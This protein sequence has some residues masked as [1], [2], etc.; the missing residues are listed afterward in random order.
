MASRF[1]DLT[2][3]K[4]VP[5]RWYLRGPFRRR[6]ELDARDYTE[7]VKRPD[8]GPLA[9]P[10]LRPGKPLDWTEG[11][12]A[13][14]VVSEKVSNILRE[15]APDDVQLFPVTVKG[16]RERYYI[17]NAIHSC[18]CVDEKR[19]QDVR[20]W[21]KDDFRPDLA[22]RY[23]VIHKLIINPRRTGGHRLFRVKDWEVALIASQEIKDA[24]EEAGV[25]GA[26][27]IPV[28]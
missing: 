19:S 4:Y 26:E 2:D 12:Y 20:R 16:R 8:P 11:D 18:A 24:F 21:T 5:G 14:P 17:A 1:Y 10:L 6:T 22:G 28:T 13:M 15:L 23:K 27:F 9:I 7:G 25:L 3:D